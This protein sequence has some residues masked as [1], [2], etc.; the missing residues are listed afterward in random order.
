MPR[1]CFARDASFTGWPFYLDKNNMY[2][3]MSTCIDSFWSQSFFSEIHPHAHSISSTQAVHTPDMPRT[4][5]RGCSPQ[6]S[7]DSEA[8]HFLSLQ[9]AFTLD[10]HHVKPKRLGC[11]EQA[12]LNYARL[13]NCSTQ[14]SSLGQSV[15]DCISTEKY[16]LASDGVLLVFPG[17]T[18]RTFF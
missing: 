6:K 1:L 13:Q 4:L 9:C 12:L 16:S 18:R 10:M 7:W 5:T 11:D 8:E 2:V 15:N 17:T 14:A 3:G